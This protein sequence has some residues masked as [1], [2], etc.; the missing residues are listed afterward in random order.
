MCGTCW[1][2]FLSVH[3][4]SQKQKNECTHSATCTQGCQSISGAV[5]LHIA[6]DRGTCVNGALGLQSRLIL[7][8]RLISGLVAV[9]DT[10]KEVDGKTWKGKMK[11]RNGNINY[12]KCAHSFNR[13]F[14]RTDSHPHGESDPCTRAQLHHEV[15]VDKNAKQG[16]PGKQGD[17]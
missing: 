15:D 13:M 6:V 14:N 3:L 11:L 2:F 10:I 5:C 1:L 7:A 4:D 16:Q 9:L 12:T 8:G 17:L